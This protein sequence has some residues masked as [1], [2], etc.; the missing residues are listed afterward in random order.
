MRDMIANELK[1]NAVEKNKFI[2]IIDEAKKESCDTL[3]C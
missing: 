2:I 3:V 1:L